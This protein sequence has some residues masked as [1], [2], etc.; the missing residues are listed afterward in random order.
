MFQIGYSI[1]NSR[2]G[3][4]GFQNFFLPKEN[5]EPHTIIQNPIHKFKTKEG[6]EIE[7][8]CF[9]ILSD[10]YTFVL[11]DVSTKS[12]TTIDPADPRPLIKFIEENKLNLTSILTTHKHWDHSG[13]N[14]VLKK[15]YPNVKIY[16]SSKDKILELTNPIKHKDEISIENLNFTIFETPCHTDGHVIYYLQDENNPILFTGDTLFTGGCGKF[17]EGDAKHMLSNFKVIKNLPL[18]TLIFCGHEYSIKNI[19]FGIS[20]EKENNKMKEKFKECVEFRKLKKACIPTT[21]EDELDI[22]IFLRTNLENVKEV[23]GEKD[24]INALQKLR[25]MKDEM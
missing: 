20:I 9:A 6:K 5:A 17:F 24:E 15:K 4:F 18:N 7:L 25:K 12:I 10:N 11:H 21:I 14:E 22:N 13:G 23:L 2:V 16:G 19:S 8:L 3:Y 1:F